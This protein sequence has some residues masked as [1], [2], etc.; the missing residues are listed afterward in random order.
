MEV[1]YVHF[2]FKRD[3]SQHLSWFYCYWDGC[4]FEASNFSQHKNIFFLQRS[5]WDTN[6]RL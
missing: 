5:K 1:I 4:I 3:F 2:I 6:T